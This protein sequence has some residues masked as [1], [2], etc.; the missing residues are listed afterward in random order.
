MPLFVPHGCPCNVIRQD[1][2]PGAP[3]TPGPLLARNTPFSTLSFS[4]TPL[5]GES[6]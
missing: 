1:L 4:L 5:M 3:V 2:S 6:K